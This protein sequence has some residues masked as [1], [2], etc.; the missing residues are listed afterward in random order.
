MDET[1]QKILEHV[2]KGIALINEPFKEIAAQLGIT[3]QE[4]IARLTK[5]RQ[6]GAIRRFGASI[7]PNKIGFSA[8][9]L[10]AW[11]VPQNRVQEVGFYLS[12]FPEISHCYERKVV[13]QR[14]EYNVYTVLHAREREGIESMVNRISVAASLE[15]YR[16]LFSK[17]DLKRTFSPLTSGAIQSTSFPKKTEV[18]E[19]ARLE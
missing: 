18:D 7:K 13:P 4:V 16:I 10:V 6:E 14:W 1:N 11:K 5:L 8:N 12:R 3:Q 15:E 2:E 17:R 9:A 19:A